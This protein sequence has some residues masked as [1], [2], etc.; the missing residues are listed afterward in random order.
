MHAAD[1]EIGRI[2][3]ALK[4]WFPE[5]A[6]VKAAEIGDHPILPEEQA[7][8]ANA[9]ERRQREFATGRF[10][11][12]QGLR[13]FGMP[14]RPLMIGRL[15]EPLWPD[16]VIGTI[17]HDG[18]LCVVAMMRK[19]AGTEAGIGVD[20]VSLTRRPLRMDE[21]AS[22]FVTHDDE[23]SAVAAL[24]VPVDP[25]LLLFS[26]KE[27]VVKASSSRLDDF[28]DLRAIEIHRAGGLTFS[29]RGVPMRCGMFAAAT[30]EHLMTAVKI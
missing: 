28:I 24:N 9:V 7:L 4:G 2:E 10:L 17:S 13:Q 22:M 23:L 26:L 12:R 29:L 5:P 16:S 27:S 25:A 14:D 15:R 6:F 21:L 3:R 19:Q 8:V 30:G 18:A 20:L 11:A 1:G